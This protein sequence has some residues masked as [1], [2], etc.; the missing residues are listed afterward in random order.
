MKYLLAASLIVVSLC[1]C[2]QSDTVYTGSEKLVVK[3]VEITEESV[4]Y[5]YPNETLINTVNKNTVRRI[6]FSSGRTQE[7]GGYSNYKEVS[8]WRDWESVS[9]AVAEHE[10]KGLFRLE[11]V[12]S[13]AKGATTM[14]NINR[15][16]DR[17]YKKL[18]IEAAMLGGNVI[19]ISNEKVEGNRNYGY[20]STSAETQLSGLAYSDNIPIYDEVSALIKKYPR[21]QHTITV[22]QGNNSPDA[23]ES[24]GSGIVLL[25]EVIKEGSFLYVDA[26][27][28]GKTH[29]CR[30][31]RTSPA[32]ITLMHRDKKKLYNYVLSGM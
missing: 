8:G 25:S 29:R 12:T 9:L 22:T 23:D 13:K 26:T 5:T 14:S 4:K 1:V 27:I 31:V 2:G 17:A 19:Y 10:I 16:K 7:F 21:W 28:S 24:G 15:V 3:V 6:V 30:V 20:S 18:K 32:S 11:E